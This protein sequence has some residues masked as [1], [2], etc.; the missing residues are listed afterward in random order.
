MNPNWRD[1]STIIIYSQIN[2]E[3]YITEENNNKNNCDFGLYQA[4]LPN[5][6]D[7]SLIYMDVS[8]LLF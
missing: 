7:M 8:L 5:C 1:D 2:I 4:K 6:R 3:G